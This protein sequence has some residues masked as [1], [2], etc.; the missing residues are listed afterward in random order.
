MPLP[1]MQQDANRM[2]DS[3]MASFAKQQQAQK[4]DE[5]RARQKQLQDEMNQR[6]GN[7]ISSY[8]D[9]LRGK[10]AGDLAGNTR[11]ANARGLLYSGLK[12]GGETELKAKAGSD[13]GNYVAGVNAADDEQL[14]DAEGQLGQNR[15]TMAGQQIQNYG[16]DVY[17]NLANYEA[18]LE[19]RRRNLGMTTNIGQAA[20]G[21]LGTAVGAIV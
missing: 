7:L 14:T 18:N 6:K 5:E 20:G 8:S 16:L 21:L 15:A 1:G 9:T 13:Y 11:N 4:D 3:H 19:R 12:S 10:L 17:Q 2:A